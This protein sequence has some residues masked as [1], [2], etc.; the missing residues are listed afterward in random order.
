[1]SFLAIE[2]T[3][4]QINLLIQA[5]YTGWTSDGITATHSSCQSGY[6]T[7]LAY[8]VTAGQTYTF[9]YIVPTISGGYI[10]AQVGGT[11]GAEHTTADIYVET[12]V[13]AQDG[14]VKLFS[15]ANCTATSFNIKNINNQTGTTI[16]W[17]AINQ[18]WSDFRTL[19]PEYGW[20]IFEQ[21]L[22]CSNGTLWAAQNG[23]G[24]T[25]TNNFF[26][27]QYQSS[28]QVAEAKNAGVIKDFEALS[29]QANQLLVSAIDGILSSNG[30]VSTLIDTDFIK[31]RLTGSGMTLLSYQND[32]VYS[33]SFLGDQNEEGIVNGSTLRGNWLL[34]TLQT[35]DG[36]KPL[37][38]F[39]LSIRSRY[40]PVGS[41]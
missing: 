8:P 24:T 11:D 13:A 32:N 20:S 17:S 5:N 18:K 39:S 40:V 14:F 7:L 23:G 22:M 33:A 25:P 31:Q 9:S 36:S 4:I 16:I 41:R 2:N 29:Y 1:M 26:G 3:P 21:T 6:I 10:Q 37:A 34:A 30:Q 28:I 35:V 15:N 38:L 19:Y 12:L 27:T